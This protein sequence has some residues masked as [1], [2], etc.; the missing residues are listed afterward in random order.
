ML[1]SNL[2]KFMRILLLFSETFW[3]SGSSKTINIIKIILLS[4][5]LILFYIYIAQSAEAVEYTDCFFAEG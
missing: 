3:S 4:L 5:L 2:I 1:H